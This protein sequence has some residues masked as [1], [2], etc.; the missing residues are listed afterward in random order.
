MANKARCLAEEVEAI[1]S[2]YRSRSPRLQKLRRCDA[3]GIRS[4]PCYGSGG[5]VMMAV[6]DG[7]KYNCLEVDAILV[8]VDT[9]YLTFRS[10][11]G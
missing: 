2:S 11:G 8:V 4:M 3:D 5:E 9:E 7:H 6:S 1:D 10:R